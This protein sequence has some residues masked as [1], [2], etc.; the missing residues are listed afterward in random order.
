MI[1]AYLHTH[2]HGHDIYLVRAETAPSEE[3]VIE[4]MDVNFEEDREDEYF[5]LYE[6][7]ND[8]DIPTM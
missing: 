5:E 1:Y 8:A 7:F 6:S 3:S 4:K 2:R